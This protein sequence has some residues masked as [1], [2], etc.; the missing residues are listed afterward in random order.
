M[1]LLKVASLY[2]GFGLFVMRLWGIAFTRTLFLLYS[3]FIKGKVSWLLDSFMSWMRTRVSP[4]IL[5][6]LLTMHM[7]HLSSGRRFSHICTH[8]RF[9]HLMFFNLFCAVYFLTTRTVSFVQ[10]TASLTT[11]GKTKHEVSFLY[12]KE[13][14][15]YQLPPQTAHGWGTSCFP[16]H[17][18]NKENKKYFHHFYLFCKSHCPQLLK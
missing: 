13:P 16:F 17:F 5:S 12:L 11:P 7:G 8:S 18:P 10:G 1:K 2:P 15:K 6:E 9:L 14:F 4:G 3:S